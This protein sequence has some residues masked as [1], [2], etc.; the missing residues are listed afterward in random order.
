MDW[1]AM[2][3]GILGSLFLASGQDKHILT[4]LIL[5]ATA[6]ACWVV[7]GLMEG[8]ITIAISGAGFFAIEAVGIYK[9]LK[10]QQLYKSRRGN[11][12]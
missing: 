6:S 5:Y 8:P 11:K 3:I 10:Q 7:F 12:E 2:I 4:T 1:I 9:R